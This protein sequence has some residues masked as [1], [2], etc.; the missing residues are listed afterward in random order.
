MEGIKKSK[1]TFKKHLTRLFSSPRSKSE[2]E[3]GLLHAHNTT[4]NTYGYGEREEHTIRCAFVGSLLGFLSLSFFT[5]FIHSY[6]GFVGSFPSPRSSEY[7]KYRIILY[8]LMSFT[9][10]IPD[11]KWFVWQLITFFFFFFSSLSEFLL[12][13]PFLF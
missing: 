10:P 7:G 3:S 12:Y 1:Y 9:L 2:S 11:F 8:E 6:P 4:H 13:F 5:P